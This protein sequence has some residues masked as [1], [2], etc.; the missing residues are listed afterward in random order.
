MSFSVNFKL[1]LE[2]FD[3]KV[4]W[5]DLKDDKFLNIPTLDILEKLW[6][7][8]VIFLNTEDESESPVDQ[9]ARVLVEKK[10]TYEL[11]PIQDIEN[12]AY[13]KGS[14]NPLQYKR[15]F[16]LTFNCQFNLKHFPFDRQVCTIVLKKV[17]K[18]AKFMK[19]VPKELIYHGPLRLTKFFITKLDMVDENDNHL[20]V[21][22]FLKRRVSRHIQSTYLPSFCILVIAQVLQ[23][24]P[25]L[26]YN[27]LLFLAH[28]I[29]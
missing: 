24:Y 21:R 5:N 27:P 13:Y 20:K 14:E 4:K 28:C 23:L 29:L 22:L 17:S 15:N 18:E 2:W 26:H 16:E 6:F 8:V 3:S 9:K 12:V 10:G 19:L 7:P 1:S 11:S 25:S